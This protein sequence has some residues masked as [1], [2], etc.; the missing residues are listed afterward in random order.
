MFFEAESRMDSSR[1]SPYPKL[2][3]TIAAWV[4]AGDSRTVGVGGVNGGTSLV[5]FF[6]EITAPMAQ[7]IYLD[8]P[9]WDAYAKLGCRVCQR[10]GHAICDIP[11]CPKPGCPLG[12]DEAQCGQSAYGHPLGGIEHTADAW[13]ALVCASA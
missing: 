2:H 3:G 1:P 5:E 6:A 13:R 10:L 9:T 11:G 7:G 8:G 12:L 4:E